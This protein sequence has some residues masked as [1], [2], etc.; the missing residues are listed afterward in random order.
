MN[1]CN[2][3]R[4]DSF[5]GNVGVEWRQSIECGKHVSKHAD[6][7]RLQYLLINS[8]VQDC[9]RLMNGSNPN[10]LSIDKLDFD[11]YV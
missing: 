7:T 8:N 5:C 4:I 1:E 11:G 3:T 10:G 9:L 6:K 2:D